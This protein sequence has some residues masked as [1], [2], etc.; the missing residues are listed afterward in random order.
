MA[1]IHWTPGF[2]C[3]GGG[4]RGKGM[5]RS[6][7]VSGGALRRRKPR[8]RRPRRPEAPPRLRRPSGSRRTQR[9]RGPTTRGAR[10]RRQRDAWPSRSLEHEHG[11]GYFVFWV[12][13]RYSPIEL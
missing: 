5:E 11:G 9:C 3:D 6:S 1:W 7:R 4:R 8:R 2:G 12:F 10:R 13:F